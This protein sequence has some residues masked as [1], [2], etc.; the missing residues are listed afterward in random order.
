[1]ALY[2][3]NGGEAHKVAFMATIPLGEIWSNNCYSTAGGFKISTIWGWEYVG[4]WD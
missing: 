1:L 4:V 2:K 3:L